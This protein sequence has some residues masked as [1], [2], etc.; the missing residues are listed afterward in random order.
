MVQKSFYENFTE[1]E[2]VSTSSNNLNLNLNNLNDKNYCD[3]I[4]E[5]FIN[6][7][8]LENQICQIVLI[9]SSNASKIKFKYKFKYS[10]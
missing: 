1:I 9:K 10:K 2:D 5:D 7:N 6:N 4:S 3:G 8:N